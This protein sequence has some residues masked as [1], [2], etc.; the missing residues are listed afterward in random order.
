M[1]CGP[2]FLFFKEAHMK[3]KAG[4]GRWSVNLCGSGNAVH[5]TYGNAT[6]HVLMED[7]GDLAGALAQIDEA[8]RSAEPHDKLNDKSLQ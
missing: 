1:R 3:L 7:I 8:L 2:G 6:L 5:L 4:D